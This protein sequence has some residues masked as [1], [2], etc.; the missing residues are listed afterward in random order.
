MVQYRYP[1]PPVPSGSQ[2]TGRRRW[3]LCTYHASVPAGKVARIGQ[4][5][6]QLD[7]LTNIISNNIEVDRHILRMFVSRVRQD[8]IYNWICRYDRLASPAR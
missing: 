6:Q 8:T 2:T 5:E 4:C 7:I 1:D 3:C